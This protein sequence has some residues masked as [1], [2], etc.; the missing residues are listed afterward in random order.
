[1][2]PLVYS[3][4]FGRKENTIPDHHHHLDADPVVDNAADRLR[5]LDRNTTVS[6]VVPCYNEEIVLP[7]LIERLETAAEQWG[8][9]YEVILVDD[10]SRD[11]TWSLIEQ[12]CAVDPRW[13]GVALGRNFGHQIAVWAGLDHAGGDV[14]TVL[15]ADLQDPP[16]VV[17]EF[18]EKW[19]E[20]YDVIYAVRTKR[21]EN[22]LR[23]SAYF[24]F[25]RILA[26]L[27]DIEI[28]LD[29]GDFSVVDRRVVDAMLSS[30]EQQPFIR[31]LRSW[32]GFKQIGVTYERAARAAGQEKY[33]LSKLLDLATSGLVSFSSRP[34]HLATIFGFAIAALAAAGAV[35][36][37]IQ[38]TFAS[39]FAEIGLGP[40]PGF[41]TTVIAIL[42]LGAVQLISI[43]ILGEYVGRIYDNVKGRPQYTV[44]QTVGFDRTPPK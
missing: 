2:A 3:R 17:G 25:Y 5:T 24:L 26:L 14:I 12:K 44:G 1:V 4:S 28:P 20:G 19:C 15:D 7:S 31:G 6:V 27:A 33:T 13:R 8:T 9:D 11:D 39:W 22:F 42:F 36:T 16:E 34:L 43:G 32:V 21:K 35:F 23:R 38:R 30:R 37:L 29:S 41:A 18:L 40:V 10:G